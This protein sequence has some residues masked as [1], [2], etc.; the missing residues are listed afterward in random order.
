MYLCT[1]SLSDNSFSHG[2]AYLEPDWIDIDNDG[3]GVCTYIDNGE[4]SAWINSPTN[5][6]NDGTWCIFRRRRIRRR[7]D[8]QTN[9]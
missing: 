6:V 3:R 2:A 7:L 1:R 9:K 8:L 5:F 4:R